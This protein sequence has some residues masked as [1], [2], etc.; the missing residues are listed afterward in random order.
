[1]NDD[2]HDDEDMFQ[3]PNSTDTKLLFLLHLYTQFQLIQRSS[4]VQRNFEIIRLH[5]L[6]QEERAGINFKDGSTSDIF[7]AVQRLTQFSHYY[8]GADTAKTMSTIDKQLPLP[9]Q[10]AKQ[11]CL[12]LTFTK[13]CM[14]TLLRTMLLPAPLVKMIALLLPPPNLWSKR[15]DGLRSYE[16]PNDTIVY[17]LDLID[18][19]LEEG[20]ILSAFEKAQI[21]PPSP[22][23]TWYDWKR[24]SRPN[25][26]YSDLD[27]EERWPLLYHNPLHIRRSSITTSSLPSFR[28]KSN[29]TLCELRRSVGYSSVLCQNQSLTDIVSILENAPYHMPR[30]IID[31]L[32]LIHDV[33]SICR[34]CCTV[35]YRSTLMQ[36]QTP[37]IVN[38]HVSTKYDIIALVRSLR[39][40]YDVQTELNEAK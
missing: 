8:N 25:E 38:F 18:E 39:R 29:P 37:P 19:I 6:L 1:M 32:I 4:R 3:I 15:E 13:Q 24:S 21:P 17:A 16:S 22:Y 33:A 36:N 14:Q 23:R 31:K 7:S 12:P 26:S 27:D 40:W 20:G 28:D 5:R 9:Q 35:T 2:A 10:K 34:R 30:Q 11:S